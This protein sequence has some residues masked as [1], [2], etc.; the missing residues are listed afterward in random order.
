[1]ITA[2]ESIE[3]DKEN[4][5]SSCLHLALERI[6]THYDSQFKAS[7]LPIMSAIW[8]FFTKVDLNKNKAVCNDCKTELA[9]NGGTTSGLKNHLK[10][11]HKDHYQQ[12]SNATPKRQDTRQGMIWCL[13]NQR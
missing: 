7:C 4:L 10:S 12:L 8:K 1:M 3:T 9:C 2:D 6:T 11:K 5:F 13:N